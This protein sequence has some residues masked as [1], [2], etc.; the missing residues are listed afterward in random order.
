MTARL[1]PRRLLLAEADDARV[2]RAAEKLARERIAEVAVVGP[3]ATLKETARRA[4]TGLGG[5]EAIES[6]DAG[7]IAR[8][9]AELRAARG[10]RLGG[11]ELERY[12]RDPLFQAACRVRLGLA[13][14]FVCGAVRTT[15]DV[16][17]ASL[18]LVGLAP[19]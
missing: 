11:A 15:A 10:E 6:G 7:E 3:Q 1:R 12:V 14:C 18:Y 9:A 19:N 13:D 5:V 16:L 2:V 8:T 17:R 4:G